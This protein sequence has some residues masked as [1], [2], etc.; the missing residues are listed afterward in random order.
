MSTSVQAISSAQ[1]GGERVKQA[2]SEGTAGL[3]PP[4]VNIIAQYL[5]PNPENSIAEWTGPLGYD[6]LH[7]AVAKAANETTPLT[8]GQVL[9]VMQYL[10]KSDV[11]GLAEL[12]TAASGPGRN[13]EQGKQELTRLLGSYKAEPPLPVDIDVEMQTDLSQHFD[14]E[15]LR[16]F[17]EYRT[18][19]GMPRISKMTELYSLYWGPAG[20]TPNIAEKLAVKHGTQ[21]DK[22]SWNPALQEHGNR[23][24]EIDCW[25]AFPSD[26]FGRGKTFQEQAA[27]VPVG[28][29]LSRFPEAVFCPFVRFACERERIMTDRPRTYARCPEETQGYKL[30]VGGFG[31]GGL[32]VY[33]SSYDPVSDGVAFVRKFCIGH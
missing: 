31:A 32:N 14:A 25:I 7:P 19:Q 20:A 10:K 16:A 17:H 18:S 33:F 6:I 24:I 29:E 5:S 30:V 22:Y 3:F 12:E 1:N 26:V 28:F 13:R 15:T 23:P 4:L 8:E 2:I 27:L 21:F 9:L 11:F